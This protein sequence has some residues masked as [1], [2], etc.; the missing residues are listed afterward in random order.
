MICCR[1]QR[2]FS[3][4]TA[5]FLLV[6]LAALGAYM[7]GISTTQ[8]YT[9]VYALQGAK[10]YYAAR[11]GIEWGISA[12]VGGACA[13][14]TPIVMG[15]FTVTVTCVSSAHSEN[16]LDFHVYHLDAQAQT[17]AAAYGAPGFAARHITAT[18]TGP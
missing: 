4:V 15:D 13:G 14:A 5:L 8:K 17:T 7:V 10:A 2:G 18:V 1:Y 16:G 9:T 11:S 3:L 6:V 12:S